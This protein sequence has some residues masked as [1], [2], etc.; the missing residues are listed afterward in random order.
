MA[1]VYKVLYVIRSSGSRAYRRLATGV[2][3]E[4][5]EG[6]S[7]YLRELLTMAV[8]A[9][10]VKHE[11]VWIALSSLALVLHLPVAN[12]HFVHMHLQLAVLGMRPV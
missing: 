9:Q 10:F 7:S 11:C 8:E 4:I 3:H 5:V 1:A 12:C 2:S 6:M